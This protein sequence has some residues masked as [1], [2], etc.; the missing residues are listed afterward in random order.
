M[1]TR[2]VQRRRKRRR[3]KW[4]TWRR[5]RQGL[6]K[7]Q[8]RKARRKS[9]K[10]R[11]RTRRKAENRRKRAEKRMTWKWRRQN[12]EQH[13][14]ICILVA[15]PV[16]LATAIKKMSFAKKRSKRKENGRQEK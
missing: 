4:G 15:F 7:R 16:L 11:R 5:K 14:I 9:R 10:K 2:R 3:K 12:K 6:T 8:R 1:R 13:K